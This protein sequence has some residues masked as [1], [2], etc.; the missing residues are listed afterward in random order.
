MKRCSFCEWIPILPWPVWPLAW[1]G[2]L[3]QNAVVGSM[4]LLLAVRGNIATRSMSGPPFSVQLHRTTVCCRATKR[5]ADRKIRD[6]LW[7]FLRA[8]VM[9]RGQFEETLTGTPQGGIV[10]PLLANIYLDAMDKYMESKSLK[11]SESQ[12]RRRREQGKGNC[13]Y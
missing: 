5:V 3:G 2:S 13:L 7:K 1:Q 4:T 8:G 12:R 9:H 11:L 6:L 10:S